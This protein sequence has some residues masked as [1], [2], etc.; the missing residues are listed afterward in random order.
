M[1]VLTKVATELQG[2]KRVLELTDD[3]G[4]QLEPPA[5]VTQSSSPAGGQGTEWGDFAQTWANESG[6]QTL[7]WGGRA[8]WALTYVGLASKTAPQL[9]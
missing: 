2:Q 6:A 8:P 3:A 4:R 5:S 7:S 9:E 1:T